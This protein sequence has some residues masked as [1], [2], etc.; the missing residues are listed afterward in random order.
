MGAAASAFVWYMVGE[1]QPRNAIA[2]IA[3]EKP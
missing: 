2:S 3:N 1:M